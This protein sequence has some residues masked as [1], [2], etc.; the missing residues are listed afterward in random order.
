MIPPAFMS[1]SDFQKSDISFYWQPNKTDTVRTVSVSVQ[2][3]NGICQDSK[4]YTVA[5]NNDDINLQGE[6]FT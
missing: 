6:D 1:P 5:K 2:T 3:L 4:D